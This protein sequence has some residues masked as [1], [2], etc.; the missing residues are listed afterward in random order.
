MISIGSSESPAAS[1]DS[2]E[3]PLLSVT[4]ESSSDV[5][6]RIS[7]ESA[8]LQ[9]VL[10]FLVRPQQ[11]E[12]QEILPEH[13]HQQ[14]HRLPAAQLRAVQLRAVQLRAAQLRAA[15]LREYRRHQDPLV[16]PQAYLR[17]AWLRS[18]FQR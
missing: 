1:A 2:G 18:A 7:L 3:I 4:A 15:Q 8:L 6:L 14:E 5:I 9:L 16:S 13:R 17:M 12:L 10:Q 11:A